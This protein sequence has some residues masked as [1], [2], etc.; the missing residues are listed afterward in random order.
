MGL[1][2]HARIRSRWPVQ[3]DIEGIPRNTKDR[4][5]KLAEIRQQEE[6]NMQIQSVTKPTLDF[7]NPTTPKYSHQEFPRL[8]YRGEEQSLV[9]HTAEELE[10]AITDGFHLKKSDAIAAAPAIEDEDRDESGDE[11]EVGE[12]PAPK[13]K[14]P[15][16][17][18]KK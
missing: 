7:N 18:K 16:A 3:F 5:E 9:V 6:D 13:A 4:N 2:E 8:V 12:A 15:V 10:A 14:K 17:K 11:D 1:N